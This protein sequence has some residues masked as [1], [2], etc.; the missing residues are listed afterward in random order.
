MQRKDLERFYA[1]HLDLANRGDFYPTDVQAEP[2]FHRQFEEGGFWM[3]KKGTLLIVEPDDRLV[4]H[5]EFFQT[6]SYLDEYEIAYQIYEGA[7]R[8]KGY[9]TEAVN[10]LVGYLFGLLKMNRVRLIIHPDNLASRRVAEKCGFRHEGTA[11][12]AWFLQGAYHDVEVYA[13]L[14]SEYQQQAGGR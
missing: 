2:A 9:I 13:L 12:G 10:L 11:R 4:G 5:I 7:D 8:G 1:A 14:R 3:E 6:V